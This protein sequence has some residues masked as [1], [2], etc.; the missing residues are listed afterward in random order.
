MNLN[1]P[2][3]Q[4]VKQSNRTR[5]QYLRPGHSGENASRRVKQNACAACVSSMPDAP[6]VKMSVSPNLIYKQIK[7]LFPACKALENTGDFGTLCR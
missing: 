5:L 1:T 2:R 6:I 3:F 7:F 4:R